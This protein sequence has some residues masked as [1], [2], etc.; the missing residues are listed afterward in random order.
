[1]VDFKEIDVEQASQMLESGKALFVDVRDP[2]SYQAAHVPG[3]ILLSDS[4][5]ADFVAKTDKQKPIVCYCYHGHTSQG[6]ATY[7]LDQGFKEVYS[8]MGGFESWRQT[9]KIE[10]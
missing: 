3:A 4:N 9:E 10:S 2:G 5:V 7:L 6:A 1:M 8:V